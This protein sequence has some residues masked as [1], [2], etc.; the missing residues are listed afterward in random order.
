LAERGRAATGAI[1]RT[2]LQ[3]NRE[4]RKISSVAYRY[5]GNHPDEDEVSPPDG[6]NAM[7][8]DGL[9]SHVR[10]DHR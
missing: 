2:I 7:R 3:V 10:A 6:A 5:V 4:T 9:H 8:P 1:E